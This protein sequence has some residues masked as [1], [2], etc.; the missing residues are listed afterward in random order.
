MAQR[1][2]Q[3]VLHRAGAGVRRQR[4]PDEIGG[5]RARLGEQPGQYGEP[6]RLRVTEQPRQL[7]QARVGR[8]VV[9]GGLDRRDGLGRR[10]GLD[11]RGR[12]GR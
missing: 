1:L 8:G 2:G 9:R 11:G 7:G 10:S 5:R 4:V 3:Q 6:L 12:G